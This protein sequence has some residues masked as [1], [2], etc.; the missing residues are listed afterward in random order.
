MFEAR[1]HG[2]AGQGAKLAA[3][4]LAEAAMLEE[5]RIQAFP[6]YGPERS[7]A[8]VA[9]YVR[10]DNQ[11]IRDH[12][13]ITHPTAILVLDP[14]LLDVVDV[15]LGATKETIIIINSVKLA[16]ELQKKYQLIGRVFTLDASKIA[17]ETIGVNKPNTIILGY[18]IQLSKIVKIESLKKVVAKIFDKKNRSEVVK[19]NLT[20]IEFGY[21]FKLN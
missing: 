12:F 20:A 7:G 8:P 15:D 5:K 2:R 19:T 9:S 11:E 17:L 16:S 4:L 3:Q 6:E 18:L 14:S 1:F 13:P 21:K 10:I